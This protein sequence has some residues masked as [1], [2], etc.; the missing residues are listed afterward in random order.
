VKHPHAD[1]EPCIPLCRP[2]HYFEDSLGDPA[3]C[4]GDHNHPTDDPRFSGLPASVVDTAKSA[5]CTRCGVAVVES[6]AVAGTVF[7]SLYVPAVGARERLFLCGSCGLDARE[8][9]HPE[10]ADSL[11]F[12]AVKAELLSRLL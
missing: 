4:T 5:S 3:T 1:N 10:L 12:Q 8:F 2:N 7:L 9:L 6:K 11:T